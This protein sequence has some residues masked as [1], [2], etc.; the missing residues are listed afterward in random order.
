MTGRIAQVSAGFGVRGLSFPPE[1]EGGQDPVDGALIRQLAGC[2][3]AAKQVSTWLPECISDLTEFRHPFD[4]NHSLVDVVV[5]RVHPVSEARSE[6]V[7][8][9]GLMD[10]WL[11]PAVDGH[12]MLSEPPRFVGHLA[13][14]DIPGTRHVGEDAVFPRKSLQSLPVPSLAASAQQSVATRKLPSP[15]APL[16]VV[17]KRSL[18]SERYVVVTSIQFTGHGC[19][20]GREDASG[21]AALPACEQQRHIGLS[22]GCGWLLR[23]V[24]LALAR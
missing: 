7:D 17:L 22:G 9:V 20:L 8:E 2:V 19:L 3:L 14:A 12:G 18:V 13:D 4:R 5:A 21:S 15:A 16:I 1:T 10:Q 11:F 23:L 24:S 6:A